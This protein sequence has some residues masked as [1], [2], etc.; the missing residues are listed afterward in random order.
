MGTAGY[1]KNLRST[2][3]CGEMQGSWGTV[4]YCRVLQGTLGAYWE[5]TTWVLWSTASTGQNWRGGEGYITGS[6][7]QY[8]EVP[9]STHTLPCN[10]YQNPQYPAVSHSTRQYLTLP[11][12]TSQYQ[13]Y[14]KVSL[15]PP[16]T[17][18]YHAVLHGTRTL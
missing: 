18:Q 3:D 10:T 14:P 17:P 8:P 2:A 13:Q 6:A 1:Y 5:V 11:R 12:S 7:L 9:C 16:S 15:V 4:K